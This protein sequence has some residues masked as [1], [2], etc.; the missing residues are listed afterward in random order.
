MLQP[1]SRLFHG[2]LQIAPVAKKKRADGSVAARSLFDHRGG[3][4]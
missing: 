1:D 2:T 3:R 4:F